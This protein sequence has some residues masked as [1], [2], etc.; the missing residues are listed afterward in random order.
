MCVCATPVSELLSSLEECDS[1][2]KK[3]KKN[4]F[5][6]EKEKKDLCGWIVYW[7][8]TRLDILDLLGFFFLSFFLLNQH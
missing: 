4:Q 2:K 5:L 3:T 7:L 1:A 6:V 8:K